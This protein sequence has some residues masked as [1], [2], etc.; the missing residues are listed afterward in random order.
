MGK[1][2]AGRTAMLSGDAG[3]RGWLFGREAADG[4]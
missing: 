4:R 2:D 1:N 3:V